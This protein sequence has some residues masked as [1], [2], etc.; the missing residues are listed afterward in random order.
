M[1]EYTLLN[2]NYI[3]LV[4]HM[5]WE[6]IA[7]FKLPVISR[8][9]CIAALVLTVTLICM[10]LLFLLLCCRHHR[11]LYCKTQCLN[12]R[13][14]WFPWETSLTS[15]LLFWPFLILFNAVYERENSVR[16]QLFQCKQSANALHKL[17]VH[18]FP[19]NA[20]CCNSRKGIETLPRFRVNKMIS[21][22]LS[23]HGKICFSLCNNQALEF[24]KDRILLSY[25]G[26]GI[27]AWIQRNSS[28]HETIYSVKK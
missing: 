22:I 23:T 15:F 28:Y 11:A 20:F 4:K 24:C 2:A 26:K 3:L 1:I 5:T 21:F 18:G 8:N 16:A 13:H 10:H 12:Y 6:Y 19:Q 14:F 25:I 7:T 17:L 9:N 27:P